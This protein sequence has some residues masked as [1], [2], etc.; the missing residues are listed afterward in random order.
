MANLH[1]KYGPSSLGYRDLC[2]GWTG[3]KDG[4]TTFADE[5][6]ML[7]SAAEK[8]ELTALNPEQ[9]QCVEQCLSVVTQLEKGAREVHKETKLGILKNLTFGTA[10]RVIV[11]KSHVDLVDFKFGRNPVAPAAV[12]LQGW[13]YALGVF[14]RWPRIPRV[15]VWFLLPR[16][17]VVD[18]HTFSRADIPMMEH[19]IRAIIAK[20]ER[21]AETGDTALLNPCEAACLYCGA[22]LTCPKFTQFALA[23]AQKYEPLAVPAEVHSSAITDPSQMAILYSQAKVLERMVDSVKEHATQL[24]KEHGGALCDKNGNPVFELGTRAGERS[25]NLGLGLPILS[26]YL[27]DREL[28]SIAK[29]PLGKALD[30]IGAKQK[31]GQKGKV[32]G[33]VEQKLSDAQAISSG[34]GVTYLRKSKPAV[35]ELSRIDLNGPIAELIDQLESFDVRIDELEIENKDLRDEVTNLREQLSQQ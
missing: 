11:H 31:R 9:K 24:A 12:N 22:K 5:G 4:D 29:L 27:D 15:R 14:E 10:D 13:A 17:D 16:L 8:N 30:L 25:L 21:Y 28:L 2:A 33:E 3:D 34:E 19:T 18:R 26:E 32:I 1:S 20:C 7:H 23:V 6:T 35:A